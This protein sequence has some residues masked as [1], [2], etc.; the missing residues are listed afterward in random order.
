MTKNVKQTRRKN[1]RGG[2]PFLIGPIIGA[3]AA[4]AEIAAKAAGAIATKTAIAANAGA[5][6]IGTAKASSTK[7]T[8]ASV[9]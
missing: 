7:G 8:R 9:G 6:A 2:L 1:Q 3:I 4:K 5:M